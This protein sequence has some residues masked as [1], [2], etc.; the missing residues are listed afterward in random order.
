LHIALFFGLALLSTSPT[1]VLLRYC[2]FA[3]YPGTVFAW[4]MAIFFTLLTLGSLWLALGRLRL[5][6]GLSEGTFGAAEID[7]RGAPLPYRMVEDVELTQSFGQRFLSL[8]AAK[9]TYRFA[10]SREDA[11]AC[12]AFILTHAHAAHAAHTT[13]TST[14]GRAVERLLRAGETTEDWAR[15]LDQMGQGYRDAA[16]ESQTLREIVHDE[17]MGTEARTAAGYILGRRGE[18]GGVPEDVPLLMVDD[19]DEASERSRGEGR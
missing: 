2:L 19:E 5:S 6:R 13:D 15:R 4:P 17:S 10:V 8:R 16:V 12:Q 9:E 14:K 7:L 11:V 18:G 3:N 1:Y